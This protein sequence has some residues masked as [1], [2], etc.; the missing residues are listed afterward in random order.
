MQLLT[1]IL[2]AKVKATQNRRP[3]DAHGLVRPLFYRPPVSPVLLSKTRKIGVLAR[4]P[5]GLYFA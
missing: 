3:L 1:E 2:S 5:M 4:T